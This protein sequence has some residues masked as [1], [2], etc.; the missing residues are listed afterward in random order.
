MADSNVTVPINKLMDGVHLNVTVT[1]MRTFAVRLWI[2][3]W[4]FWLGALIAGVPLLFDFS[5]KQGSDDE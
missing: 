2:A 5:Y 1:G 3:R 4:F